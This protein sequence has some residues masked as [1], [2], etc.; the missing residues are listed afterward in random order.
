MPITKDRKIHGEI[1]TYHEVIRVGVAYDGEGGYRYTLSLASYKDAEAKV[2][3]QPAATWTSV[4][5]NPLS[6]PRSQS[7]VEAEMITSG[8]LLGGVQI[9]PPAPLDPIQYARDRKWR[10]IKAAKEAEMSSPLT[11]PYGVFDCDAESEK[12][13][14]GAIMLLQTLEGMGTP[15]TVDFVLADNS[16]VT[17]TTAQMVEVGLIMGAR[18]QAAISKA[19]NLRSA[20]EAAITVEEVEAVVWV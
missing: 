2:T 13:I 10:Q 16:V 15:T 17:L 14:T 3:E 9:A 20:I 6:D 19:S 12:R 1:Y 11:T 7:E 8:D 5:R 4:L 18:V